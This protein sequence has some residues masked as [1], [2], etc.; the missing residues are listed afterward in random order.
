MIELYPENNDLMLNNLRLL[1]KIS[2]CEKCCK[3]IMMNSEC[4][5]NIVK[6]FKIYKTNTYI[7]IRV[8]FLL[9]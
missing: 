6:F 9:A 5:K 3:V 2:L 4:I 7:I 1:S 8:S